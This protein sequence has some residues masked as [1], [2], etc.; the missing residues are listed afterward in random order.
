M[1]V[2]DIIILGL[3]GMGAFLGFKKGFLY[4]ISSLL[5]FGLAY[6]FTG[7]LFMY[8]HHYLISEGFLSETSSKWISYV[9]C[10]VAIIL[11]VKLTTKLIVGLLKT[12]G[13]NFVNRFAG[14]LV[15]GLKW[16]LIISLIVYALYDLKVF[17]KE[18]IEQNTVVPIIEQIG[19][20]LVSALGY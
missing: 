15:G 7:K 16:A 19:E 14:A 4:Q 11:L 1:S 3:V 9:L 18:G 17:Q 5:G 20:G 8:L 13:L 10:F 12:L 2:A 6:L